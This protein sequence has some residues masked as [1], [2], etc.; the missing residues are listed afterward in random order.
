MPDEDTREAALES[1]KAL[2]DI[3]G[4]PDMHAADDAN[5]VRSEARLH[6]QD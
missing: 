1:Q 5:F 3:P 6:D 4:G 2:K